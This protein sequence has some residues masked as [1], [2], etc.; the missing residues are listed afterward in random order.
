MKQIRIGVI[1]LAAM[2]LVAFV[3]TSAASA[4]N[5]H[6]SASAGS[7]ITGSVAIT[8]EGEKEVKHN[9]VFKVTGNA[10]TCN[11]ISFTGETTGA[12]AETEKVHPEYSNCTAFGF[13]GATINTAGCQYVFNANTTLNGGTEAA[14]N[15]TECTEKGGKAGVTITVNVPFIAKCVARVPNQN[16][17]NGQK[18]GNM[19]STPSRD[20]TVTTKSTNITDEVVESTGACPLAV[21]THNTAN[22]NAATYEGVS[23]VTVAGGENWWE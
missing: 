20:M 14:V 6:T 5:F 13:A 4:A 3:G 2:A 15:L 10:V 19:G 18:Y 21:G 16:G 1:A 22:G 9:H 7:A 17:I 12:T 23:T 8:K 11:T